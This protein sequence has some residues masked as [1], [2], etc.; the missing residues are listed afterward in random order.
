MLW[1]CSFSL[2]PFK[3]DPSPVPAHT[4]THTHSWPDPSPPPSPGHFNLPGSH[5]HPHVTDAET[6]PKDCDGHSHGHRPRG[7]HGGGGA[8]AAPRVGTGLTLDSLCSPN[9]SQ[10]PRLCG[11]WNVSWGVRCLCRG[12]REQTQADSRPGISTGVG[13]SAPPSATGP[14]E[15][16]ASD[17]LPSLSARAPGWEGS[18]LVSDAQCLP[19][20]APPHS[21]QTQK[22][23]P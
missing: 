2:Q 23:C 20:F 19:L 7:G 15:P 14:T 10:S 18:S 6:E 8:A 3:E 12:R 17:T 5:V 16:Q 1:V 21:S 9:S 22:S 13:F 11:A 4:H